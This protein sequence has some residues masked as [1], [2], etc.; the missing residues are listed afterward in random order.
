MSEK[1]QTPWARITILVAYVAVAI[2]EIYGITNLKTEFSMGLF[3]PEG[4]TQKFYDM[5]LAH[6]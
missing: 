5:D 3:I 2:V 4:P 1:I 6:F